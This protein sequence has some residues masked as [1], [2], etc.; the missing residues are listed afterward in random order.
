MLIQQPEQAIGLNTAMKD[1]RK[2]SSPVT[3]DLTF[4]KF[5]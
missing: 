2:G 3:G 4:F 1:D 5:E